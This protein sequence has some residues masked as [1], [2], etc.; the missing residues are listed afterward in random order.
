VYHCSLVLL[1][2][3]KHSA[4]CHCCC[5][6]VKTLLVR[7]K[8]SGTKRLR[9]I[10]VDSPCVLRQTINHGN[11]LVSPFNTG[12]W[13]CVLGVAGI[14]ATTISYQCVHGLLQLVLQS[15]IVHRSHSCLGSFGSSFGLRQVPL[16][17]VAFL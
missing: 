12:D 16:Q 3:I 7:V 17:A 9:T 1:N 13:C 11:G 4:A 15:V 6:E 14:T 2:P 5:I 10:A 8:N